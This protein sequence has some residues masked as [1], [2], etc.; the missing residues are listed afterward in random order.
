[1]SVEIMQNQASPT[2]L[3]PQHLQLTDKNSILLTHFLESDLKLGLNSF[4]KSIYSG[5]NP[6]TKWHLPLEHNRY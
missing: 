2:L 1:M 5:P 4:H 3:L 6:E